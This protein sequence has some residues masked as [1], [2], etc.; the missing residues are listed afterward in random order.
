[1]SYVSFRGQD[2]NKQLEE[3]SKM[4]STLDKQRNAIKEQDCGPC[5]PIWSQKAKLAVRSISSSP[6]GFC[7]M[8]V[9]SLSTSNR[10]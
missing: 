4:L 6:N 3:L 9:S 7:V 1:M 8:P 10:A 2:I 5:E